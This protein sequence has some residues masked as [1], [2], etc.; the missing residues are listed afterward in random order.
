MVYFDCACGESLKKPKVEKH[1]QWCKMHRFTCID[2][3]KTFVGW[4]Y[5]AHTTCMSEAQK[6]QGNLYDPTADNRIKK[7]A[8]KQ[9]SWVSSVHAAAEGASG[10]VQQQ[11]IKLQEYTNIP[12]KQKP[13]MNFVSNSLRIWGADAEA[14]WA[15]IQAAQ[16]AKEEPPAKKEEP[17]CPPCPPA[18][19]ESPEKTPAPTKRKLEAIID[20]VLEKAGGKL[21]WRRL[22][23]MVVAEA[24]DELQAFKGKPESLVLARTPDK[25]LSDTDPYVRKC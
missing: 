24:P 13:F 17:V 15:A 3:M 7:G 23:E 8:L 2:C 25:Y 12:R 20:E 10:K 22:A 11:L 1:M 14:L 4:E 5:K 19:K 18:K 9:D 16:P 6:Y 21:K